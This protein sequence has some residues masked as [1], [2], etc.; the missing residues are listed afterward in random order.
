MKTIRECL[1]RAGELVN[2]DSARLD[3]ELLLAHVVQR[4]R[5]YVFTWPERCLSD[6]EQ[7]AFDRLMSERAAGRPVAHLLGSREFWGLELDVDNSTLIPRPDT[8]TLVE[9][10]LGLSLPA[11]AQVLDLG[12]GT[13]A[14]ALALA[15]EHPQ[16]RVTAVDYSEPAVA[17]AERNRKKFGLSNVTVQLSNWFEQV[18]PAHLE[19]PLA[20]EP[21]V[22]AQPDGIQA[23]VGFQLIVSNPPYIDEADPHLTQG[24]VCFEPL[25]ALV[26]ADAGLA[27][28]KH[29]IE[30]GREYLLPGGWLVLEHGYQQGESVRALLSSAGYTEVRTV[31]DYGR[32]DRI[33]LGLFW[34]EAG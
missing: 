16:W 24:D 25:S 14:I 2:S 8:E 10:V 4:D 3:V 32:N 11:H 5:T 29:I 26:A 23:A 34:G 6:S 1:Q 30:V 27:D 20:Q 13:G 28:L 17:L 21:L 15:S 12:T 7:A 18:E 33:S 9:T 31:Q 22:E 19:E